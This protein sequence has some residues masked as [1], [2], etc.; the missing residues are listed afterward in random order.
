MIIDRVLR[1]RLLPCAF[2]VR[3]L[4]SE[5]PQTVANRSD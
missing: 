1:P 3:D 4:I 2:L 5:M